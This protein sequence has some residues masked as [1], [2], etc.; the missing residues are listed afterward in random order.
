MTTFSELFNVILTADK[1]L[2]RK[3]ARQ[4]RKLLYSSHRQGQYKKI[5]SIIENASEEYSKITE[6]FRQ[7]NF[8]IAISVLYY[9]H[10]RENQPDFLFPWLF[11]LL[12]HENGN[13]RHAAVRMFENELGPLT[14]HIRFPSE[15]SRHDLSPELADHILLGLFAN[16]NNLLSESW[17]PA[18]KKYKYISSLPSGTY[19]SVQIIL[20]D[21][22]DDCGK[23]YVGHMKSSLHLT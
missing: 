7:E 19:K 18:Y 15:I 23:Q 3:A 21:L 22:E 12:R 5:G 4:V 2:S 9:L 13:I 1:E 6:D 16:L 8:V 10:N 14:Y 20:S 11:D 17:E